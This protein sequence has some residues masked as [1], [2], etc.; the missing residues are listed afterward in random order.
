VA[1]RNGSRDVLVIDFKKARLQNHVGFER[2]L[3]NM[4]RLDR[5]I[6]KWPES[7]RAVTIADRLRTLREYLKLQPGLGDDW[8]E[9]ARRIRTRHL[10]HA[11][12]RK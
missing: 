4:V 6:V 1:G 10:V 3:R 5:S 11:V 7:R 12:S 9:V 2:R 8:K